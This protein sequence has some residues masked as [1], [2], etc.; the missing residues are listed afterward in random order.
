MM[1]IIKKMSAILIK[2]NKNVFDQQINKHEVF[3]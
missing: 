1:H 3:I 2:F